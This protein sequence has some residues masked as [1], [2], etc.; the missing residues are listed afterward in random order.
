VSGGGMMRDPP[1]ASSRVQVVE[2]W[3][4]KEYFK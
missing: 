1:V 3:A 2:K 4:V